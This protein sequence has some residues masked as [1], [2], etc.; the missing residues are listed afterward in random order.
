M[1]VRFWSQSA[2]ALLKFI[3]IVGAFTV[4]CGNPTGN[5]TSTPSPSSR[6]LGDYRF[7][8]AIR[9]TKQ[10]ALA[11]Q[12]EL[13]KTPKTPAPPKVTLMAAGG[14]PPPINPAWSVTSWYIDGQ[15]VSGVASDN[16]SCTDAAHPCR[17]WS[18]ISEGRWGGVVR[19]MSGFSSIAI[20]FI[21]NQQAGDTF[22]LNPSYEGTGNV[23]VTGPLGAAQQIGTGTLA[24][25]VA[26]N[27]AGN[28]LLRATL[29]PAG[30][31]IA[32]HQIIFDSTANAY[33]LPSKSLGANVWELTQPYAPY[34]SATQIPMPTAQVT[35]SNGDSYITYV[36]VQIN[37]EY[38]SSTNGSANNNILLYHL[39]LG[40][41]SDQLM[42]TGANVSVVECVVLNYWYAVLPGVNLQPL[43]QNDD[44]GFFFQAQVKYPAQ[45]YRIVGGQ[46]SGQYLI[47]DLY[48]DGD[49][50]GRTDVAM[51]SGNIGTMYIDSVGTGATVN[52]HGDT[53]V[54][55]SLFNGGVSVIYGPGQVF[56]HGVGRIFY[57][58]GVGK[59]ASTFPLTAG[60][61]LGAGGP[62]PF[63]FDFTVDPIVGHSRNVDG[64]ALVLALDNTFGAAGLNLGATVGCATA[65]GPAACNYAP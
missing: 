59:A 2:R 50:V 24:S 29:T 27:R 30:G 63:N 3:F 25:V 40:T 4:A 64:H 38:I 10:A 1:D 43:A 11:K 42:T 22:R 28:T 15:N 53:L 54:N 32:L 9:L 17:T 35:V 60:V 57:P 33:L 18:E 58:T 13:T 48:V 16:N 5:P 26:L 8:L 20:S 49:F 23:V 31:A 61:R 46:G 6:S 62:P 47:G 12:A 37:A 51:L 7:D 44:I 56:A 41:G 45:G 34:S 14:R 55:A 52:V 39:T 36:P 21:S 65:G 19:F